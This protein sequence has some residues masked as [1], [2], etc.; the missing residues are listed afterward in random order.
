MSFCS[1]WRE[2]L[3]SAVSLSPHPP[4]KGCVPSWATPAKAADSNLSSNRISWAAQHPFSFPSSGKH[5]GKVC[6]F[7]CVSAVAHSPLRYQQ[8]QDKNC[9][10]K[11]IPVSCSQILLHEDFVLNLQFV[12]SGVSHLPARLSGGKKKLLLPVFLQHISCEIVTSSQNI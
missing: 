4:Y 6:C 3:P 11:T 7:L 5:D 1:V 10:E 9:Q 12:S 2:E 8:K